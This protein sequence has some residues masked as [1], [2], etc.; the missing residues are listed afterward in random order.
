MVWTNSVLYVSRLLTT[1]LWSGVLLIIFCEYIV[2][3]S[4]F[5]RVC[6]Y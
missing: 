2:L 6:F 1:I 4:I 3:T 5:E